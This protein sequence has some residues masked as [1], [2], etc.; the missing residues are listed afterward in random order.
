MLDIGNTIANLSI[1]QLNNLK[2]FIF[3]IAHEYIMVYNIFMRNL[4]IHMIRLFLSMII[5]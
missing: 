2:I 4:P 1:I 5:I 3:F